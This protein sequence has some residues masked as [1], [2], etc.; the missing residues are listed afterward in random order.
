MPGRVLL[1]I[2][3]TLSSAWSFRQRRELLEFENEWQ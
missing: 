1:L 3:R 2:F